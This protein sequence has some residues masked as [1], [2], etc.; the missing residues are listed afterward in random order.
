MLDQLL[1]HFV[2]A[3]EQARWFRG[4]NLRRSDLVIA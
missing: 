1:D 2:G 4:G 3:S